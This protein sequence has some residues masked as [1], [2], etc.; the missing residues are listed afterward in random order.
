MSDE[1]LE[2]AQK[3]ALADDWIS[4]YPKR[5][6]ELVNAAC[7]DE[8]TSDVAYELVEQLCRRLAAAKEG[9]TK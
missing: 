6:M 4:G 7:G 2:L 5:G 9:D 1:L 8:V 3:I